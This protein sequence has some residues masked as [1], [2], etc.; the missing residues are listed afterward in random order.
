[1]IA[2]GSESSKFWMK[3]RKDSI[4]DID[5]RKKA[6]GLPILSKVDIDV[7][8]EALVS[9]FKP[10]LLKIPGP[11]PIEEFIELYLNLKVDYK[12]L[13]DDG[14][15]L[16][17]ITFNDGYVEV[18][19]DR[20]NKELLEVEAGT[21]FID[22]ALIDDEY[23]HGRCRFTFAHEPGHWIFHR[24]MYTINKK[25]TSLFDFDHEIQTV[26]HKC[27]KKHVGH[28]SKQNYFSTDEDWREW[29]ADYFASALLMPKKSFKV[30]VEDCMSKQKISVD[31][32]RVKSPGEMFFPSRQIIVNLAQLFDVSNQA[33]ALRM[34][35]LGY[36]SDQLISLQQAI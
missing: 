31:A 28:M 15:T 11:M 5:F 34:Y 36:I 33:A 4:I 24:H 10:E 18:Y 23:Q 21:I 25:Q 22:N 17:M 13:S 19:D 35:K 2:S 6:N 1:V 3:A 26:C 29:Q 20:N 32:F 7:Y 9:D 8:A 12:N 16:G 14:N 27:L 30:A